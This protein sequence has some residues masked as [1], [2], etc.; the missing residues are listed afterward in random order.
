M[1][2]LIDMCDWR[3]KMGNV[4]LCV[5]ECEAEKYY[6]W[7]LP[8]LHLDWSTEV[9]TGLGLSNTFTIIDIGL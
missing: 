8:F 7:N 1:L 9:G 2:I 3:V 4:C 6:G 5:E